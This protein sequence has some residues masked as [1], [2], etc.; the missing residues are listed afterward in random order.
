MYCL[1]AGLLLDID[2]YDL[3]EWCALAE[4][5]A[6]SMDHNV[7][8]VAFPNFTRGCWRRQSGFRRT[9]LSAAWEA[10]LDTSSAAATAKMKAE[11]V[12]QHLWEKYDKAHR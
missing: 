2:V 8:S 5:G 12:K 3:A 7:A 6:L 9:Y 11:V 4:L 10:K 1:R